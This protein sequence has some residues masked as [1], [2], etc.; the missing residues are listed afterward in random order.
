MVHLY[1]TSPSDHRVRVMLAVTSHLT[2]NGLLEPQICALR[3]LGWDVGVIC[4]PGPISDS[5]RQNASFIETVQMSRNINPFLDLVA[6]RFL[7]KVLKDRNPDVVVAS[8]PKAGLLVM[9][10]SLT[11]R[12]PVR[13]LQLRG[14]RWDGLRGLKGVMLRRADWL[15]IMCATHVLSVSPSLSSLFVDRK[16]TKVLPTVLGPGGSKG[17][18]LNLFKLD[19]NYAFDPARPRLG[20]AGRLSAD[21]GLS[22][23]LDSFRTIKHLLPHT[24]LEVIGDLDISDPIP[25]DLLAELKKEPGLT[26]R[27]SIPRS[28]LAVAMS[29]WDLLLFPSLREG[30]PNVVIEAAACG[31]PT[32]AWMVTGVKDAVKHGTS[33]F[34][35]EYGDATGY[36]DLILQALQPQT[37]KNLRDGAITLATAFDSREVE[38]KFTSFLESV[39]SIGSTKRLV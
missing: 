10:A 9:V 26:L 23:L 31:T 17:V 20:F 5:V 24:T 3:V 2:V 19:P 6:L 35:V 1:Q 16:V 25:E 18:D 12:V 29:S 4:S 37:H 34:M 33:G 28:D 13:V 21:K 39:W 15:A 30:L 36:S 7:R 38:L 27:S 8:T 11:C 32:I 14:A 22:T